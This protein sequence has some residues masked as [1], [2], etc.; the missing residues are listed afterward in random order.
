MSF[1][2]FSVALVGAVTGE[3]VRIN[4]V[5]E[6]V[7]FKD[8]VNSGSTYEGTT[9]LLDSDLSLDGKTFEPVGADSNYFHG[10]FD[11]QGHV[12]RN[13]AM[14][15]SSRHVGLFGISYG[16]IIRN[17]ILDSSCSIASSFSGSAITFVG[18]FIGYYDARFGPCT[19][20]NSVNMASVS[21]TGSTEEELFVGGIAG[22]LSSNYETILRNCVNYGDVT[23]SGRGVVTIISGIVGNTE[24]SLSSMVVT[25]QNCLNYGT[26]AY[27]GTASALAISGIIGLGESTT[28]ENCVSAGKISYTTSAGVVYAGGLVGFI[29]SE[30]FV[31]YCY[32]SSVLSDYKKYGEEVPTTE[33]Y[34]LSYD[35]TFE[36]NETVTVGEYTGTSL[37]DALNAAANGNANYSHWLLNKNSKAVSFTI[38]NRNAPISLN[39]QVMLLPSLASEGGMSFDGWYKDSALTT[40][41]TSYDITSDTALYSLYGVILTVTF[42]KNGGDSVSFATKKAIFNSAY[43]ELPEATKAGHTLTGWFTE[44]TGGN[45]VESG[46]IVT[47]SSDHTLYA[48]WAIKTEYTI[49]FDF[50]NGTVSSSVLSVDA[51]IEYPKDIA[52]REGFTFAGW[53]PKPE[54]MPA[55]DITVKAQW[56]VTNPTECVEVV[57]SQEGLTEEN[58]RNIVNDFVPEG[59]K[60]DVE[61]VGD[62]S[63]EGTK[64]VVK[65][66]D[67]ETAKSFAEAVSASS[68]AKS[69]I[70]TFAF[71]AGGCSFSAPLA[72]STLIYFMAYFLS[73]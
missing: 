64:A 55:E 54:R 2:L 68:D 62:E 28:V 26:I 41:L 69:L 16:Q 33:S 5:D 56:T 21:F 22:R 17:V 37:I 3:E 7:Q 38:N 39:Y 15:S 44:Q 53:N 57:F 29:S 60:V 71:V 4:S 45:K 13:L 6:F 51:P 14:N 11:G 67:K 10:V 42:D 27:S 20:E 40:P 52:E 34:T 35:V 43:G 18:G 47:T 1:L 70:K 30:L 8:S 12:I 32:I 24:T 63:A 23:M 19:V 58:I 72:L 61:K 50:G 49:T 31:S 59:T 48:Q 73:F 36:L 46:N 66:N 25:I 65:F 9:V